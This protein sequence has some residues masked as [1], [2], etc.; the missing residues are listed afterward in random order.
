VWLTGQ[1]ILRD[2]ANPDVGQCSDMRYN[3]QRRSAIVGGRAHIAR[4]VNATVIP[5]DR[6]PQGYADLDHGMAKKFVLD[7]HGLIP[8]G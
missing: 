3:R 7:R 8:A 2:I 6:A 5:L 1:G 4:P